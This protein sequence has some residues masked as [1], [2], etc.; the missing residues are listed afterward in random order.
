M[1]NKDT[2]NSQDLVSWYVTILRFNWSIF[3]NVV[4]VVIG[5]AELVSAISIS[6]LLVSSALCFHGPWL[7]RA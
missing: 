6:I 4:S 5:I 7:V 1:G 2:V 3:G